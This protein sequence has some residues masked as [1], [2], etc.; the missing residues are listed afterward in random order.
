ME[1]ERIKNSEG[2]QTI[3]VENDGISVQGEKKMTTTD[4]LGC[5]YY[6]PCGIVICDNPRVCV[7]HDQYK[8][9]DIVIKNAQNLSSNAGISFDELQVACDN[10]TAADIDM[11]NHPQHYKTPKGLETIDV[12]EAFTEGLEGIE[13]T[14]TGN[15]IK[16]ACRWKRKNGIEDLEKIV[17]YANHLINHLKEKDKNNASNKNVTYESD[18]TVDRWCINPFIPTRVNDIIE[19]TKNLCDMRKIEMHYRISDNKISF[20][21]GHGSY[22]TNEITFK[23]E[24]VSESCIVASMESLV[25]YRQNMKERLKWFSK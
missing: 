3:K 15:I 21:F 1:R 11:V 24:D 10:V 16:Y 6:N 8:L 5:K 2:T 4:Y 12:I 23:L 18:V 14:D 25:L 13:A 19:F 9:D 7:D 22:Y 20:M 17:W